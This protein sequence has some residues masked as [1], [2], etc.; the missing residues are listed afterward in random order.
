METNFY[1]QS[2]INQNLTFDK[3]YPSRLEM[4]IAQNKINGRVIDDG[5]FPKRLVIINYSLRPSNWDDEKMPSWGYPN[6]E[7]GY[8]KYNANRD[9]SYYQ[10]NYDSTVWQK[11]RGTLKSFSWSDEKWSSTDI[12]GWIYQQIAELD[13]ITIEVNTLDLSENQASILVGANSEGVGVP[14]YAGSFLDVQEGS[15]D[16]GTFYTLTHES[17][18]TSYDIPTLKKNELKFRDFKVDLAHV[19]NSK[20]LILKASGDI[21]LNSENYNDEIESEF[22]IS[23]KVSDVGNSYNSN[24]SF[25]AGNKTIYIDKPGF[26]EHGHLNKTGSKDFSFS[27]VGD[28]DIILSTYADNEITLSHKEAAFSTT[29]IAPTWEEK[30]LYIPQLTFD[31]WGHIDLNTNNFLQI[32]FQSDGTYITNENLT[33]GIKFNHKAYEEGNSLA[34]ITADMNTGVFTFKIPNVKR[35][36]GG[37]ISDLD[38]L[39][40]SIQVDNDIL[41]LQTV[42]GKY[43]IYHNYSGHDSEVTSPATGINVIY[44]PILEFDDKGHIIQTDAN[45]LMIS[46]DTEDLQLIESSMN[47]NSFT[48]A[49]KDY[50]TINDI[51]TIISKKIKTSENDAYNPSRSDFIDI[52]QEPQYEDLR[53]S[54]Y[55]VLD[56]QSSFTANSSTTGNS[57]GEIITIFDS[58]GNVLKTWTYTANDG[59]IIE[60]TINIHYAHTDPNE[61]LTL[62]LSSVGEGTRYGISIINNATNF[63]VY[64][65]PKRSII[66]TPVINFNKT[67]HFKDHEEQEFVTLEFDYNQFSIASI[68]DSRI[69][70]SLSQTLLDRI[71]QLEARIAELENK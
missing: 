5:V 65:T 30:S 18:F 71:G 64:T 28:E 56:L 21:V 16:N 3:T 22:I 44:L 14:V 11:V 23:H 40:T 59:L 36:S 17:D 25:D 20:N 13:S 9:N 48:I 66:K 63:R 15:D 1:R 47:P 52:S 57:A 43:E 35:D 12:E 2:A 39:E 54:F 68:E 70:I 32:K 53:Y 34:S 8:F 7:R 10:N 26:D 27:I 29:A 42:N 62:S 31:K 6:N 4:E 50:E 69:I 46:L 19:T 24:T 33:Y 61:L 41:K 37:H 51:D 38:A 45:D 60:K 67:G 49:H 58:K 55:S